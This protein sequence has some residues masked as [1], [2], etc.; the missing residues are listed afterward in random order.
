MYVLDLYDVLTDNLQSF[1][2]LDDARL[3]DFSV[4]TARVARNNAF[5]SI[6]IIVV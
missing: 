2:A 6:L 3:G 4:P 5:P 1:L